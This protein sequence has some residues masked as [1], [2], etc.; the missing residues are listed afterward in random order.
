MDAELNGD[1]SE[2]ELSDDD[3]LDADPS[4]NPD[5][6]PSN[7]AAQKKEDEDASDEDG[8]ADGNDNSRRWYAN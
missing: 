8:V 6:D 1:V 4:Y 2:I 5:G 7:D 3:D